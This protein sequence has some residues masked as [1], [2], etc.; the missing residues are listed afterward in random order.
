VTAAEKTVGVDHTPALSVVVLPDRSPG[1]EFLADVGEAERAGVRTVWTYDHLT[2]PLLADGPWYGAVPLLAAAA[3]CTQR[4]RL[5]TL[6]ASP[7]FRHPVPFAKELMTLDRLSGGRMEAGVGAGTEGPDARVLGDPPRGRAE[8]AERFAEWLELLDRLLREPVTTLHGSR[9]TAVDAHQ[10]PGCV[11][12][13]RLPFTVAAAGPQ[14]L[15]LAARYGQGWVTYGP[16]VDAGGAGDWFAAVA[17]QSRRLTDALALEGRDPADIRRVVLI[18][19]ETAWPF[20]SAERYADTLG[21]LA[22]SGFD[23]VAVHWPRPDA[24]GVPARAMPFVAAAHGL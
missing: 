5:G 8:R 2:W 3:V 21:R 13:P 22:D 14:A 6:V 17:E 12:Q 15:G 1:P 16:Y 20:E 18:G 10:L 4:V 24:R 9:F 23:E 19:L 11:Q 7:N